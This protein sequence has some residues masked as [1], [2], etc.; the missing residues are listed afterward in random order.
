MEKSVRTGSEAL[1]QLLQRRREALGMSRRDL[2]DATHLSYPYV[3]QLETGYRM[4]SSAAAKE[5]ARVLNL[6]LDEIF[7]VTDSPRDLPPPSS[8]PDVSNDHPPARQEIVSEVVRMIQALPADSRL[9]ALADVQVQ[10]M[11]N[12]VEDHVRGRDADRQPVSSHP[13]RRQSS[14]TNH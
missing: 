12:L 14:L 7:A 3:S 5:L 4:P 2:V 9:Q 11:Q 10:V 1:G 8:A 13:A 6:S